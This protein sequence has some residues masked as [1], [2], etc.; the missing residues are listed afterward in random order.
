MIIREIHKNE[1]KELSYIHLE[2]FK[3]FFLSNL[4]KSFLY[5][6]YRACLNSQE[7]IAF[8]SINSQNELQ[9]FCVGCT[10]SKG[11]HKRLLIKNIFV[12]LFQGIIIL[13]T[14][15]KAILRL[16]KNLDKKTDKKDNGLY[17]ELLSIGVS[18]SIKGTGVGKELIKRF[19]EE[20]KER[21]CKKIA[22]TTD[23]YSNENVISFYEKMG[24]KVFY[25][26]TTYPNRR[27]YKLIKE[28]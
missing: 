21:L 10:E 7:T 25:E 23:Y 3:D 2:S 8:C 9:G 1:Y 4:G 22:L 20:A 13:F 24:Y 6:Y 18:S 16:A 28:L 14:K 12:F 26:F 17:A 19:E 15:P 11:F 5:A 27:M